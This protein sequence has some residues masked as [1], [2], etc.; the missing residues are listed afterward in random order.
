[1]AV[2]S[3]LRLRIAQSDLYPN[4]NFGLCDTCINID[5]RHL[6]T[7]C[8]WASRQIRTIA[9]CACAG[10]TGNVFPTT[11]GYS[12]PDM[13]HDTCVTYVPWCNPASLNS[14]FLWSRWRGKH[15]R[16]SWR[17]RNPHFYVSGK[18]PMGWKHI[19]HPVSDP[20]PLVFTGYSASRYNEVIVT[21]YCT[22]HNTYYWG[23]T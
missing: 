14:G 22:Q 11:A 2:K 4:I 9:S 23:L 10:N 13:H 1:M 6:Y 17:M 18:R 20:K 3:W 12:D 5:L 15:S 7:P 16:H 19:F 21:R 8:Q